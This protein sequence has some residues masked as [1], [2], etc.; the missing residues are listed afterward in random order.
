MALQDGVFSVTPQDIPRL[1]E[2]WEDSVR[3]THDFVT[4]ADIDFFRPLVRNGLTELAVAC[5][6]EDDGRAVGFVAVA[7]HNVDMLFIHSAWRGQG[8]GRRLLRH[9]VEVLDATTLDVNEQNPQAL[10]F[11][12]HMGFEVVGRSAIDGLGKPYPILHMR[13]AARP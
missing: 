10:G 9:A 3:A 13:L 11:Y 4:D 5:A 7:Q 1:V 8:I 12:Q 2:V 6:R